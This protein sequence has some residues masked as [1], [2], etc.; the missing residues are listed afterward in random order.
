MTAFRPRLVS[1]L[2]LLSVFSP[3]V[4]ST[5]GESSCKQTEF[6]WKD[7]SCC[8]PKGGPPSPPS[9]PK[10]SSCPTTHYWGSNQ[11]CCVPKNPPP[12]NSPPPQC[13]SGWN[14]DANSKK[15]VQT[16][17]PSPPPSNS[18]KSAE[19]W[20]ADTNCCLTKGGPPSPPP[21]P[22]GS[23]CPTTH[24]WGSNQGCCVPKNP[25][26]ANSPPPQCSSGWNWDANSKKCVQTPPPSPPPSNSCKSAEFWYPSNYNSGWRKR[27]HKARVARLCPSGLDACPIAGSLGGYECIDTVNDLESCGGCVTTGQG[28]DC[29]A[30][31]GAWNVGC[32]QGVCAVYSCA[33]GYKHTR[34][35]KSC[36]PV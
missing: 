27:D 35:G 22:Q 16:P 36:V 34:D 3:L 2:L 23:T 32:E 14:W 5:S 1:V 25:P 6:W 28:Q 20:W 26:P 33:F 8:L 31:P 21:P 15:C 12:A 11:A 19:F 17:P 9:P 30:I 10:G 29:T 7:T 24:Y 13:S 4:S 18:C